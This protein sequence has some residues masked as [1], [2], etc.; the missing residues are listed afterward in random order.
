VPLK[1][2]DVVLQDSVSPL[3]REDDDSADADT[4]NDSE[5]GRFE[6]ILTAETLYTPEICVCVAVKS[7]AWA[8]SPKLF[9]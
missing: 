3:L 8:A 1:S 9:R 2:P 4:D 7:S 5:R 6:L